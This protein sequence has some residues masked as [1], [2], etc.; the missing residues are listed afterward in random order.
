MLRYKTDRTW[1]SHLVRH[2]A[3]KRSGSILTTL[4]P[5]SLQG[6]GQT[7]TRISNSSGY[8]CS[9]RRWQ[10][11]WLMKVWN[12]CKNQQCYQIATNSTPTFTGQMPFLLLPNQQH[13][14]TESKSRQLITNKKHHVAKWIYM[15][16]HFFFTNFVNVY[17]VLQN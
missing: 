7:G 3:R 14:S 5:P 17:T 4:E 15:D 12:T 11:W 13:R 8:Y 2:R 1:F 10:R 6:A 16:V 9:K